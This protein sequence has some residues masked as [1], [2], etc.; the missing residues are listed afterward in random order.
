MAAQGIAS[1]PL[2]WTKAHGQQSAQRT[3]EW[4][5]ALCRTI[6]LADWQLRQE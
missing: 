4:F 2:A 3:Q 1:N 5:E 6:H